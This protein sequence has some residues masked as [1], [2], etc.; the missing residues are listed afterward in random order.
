MQEQLDEAQQGEE[1]E[2]IGRTAKVRADPQREGGRGERARDECGDDHRLRTQLQLVRKPDE[3]R[4]EP[5][6]GR[7]VHLDDVDVEALPGED[8]FVDGN[9]PRHVAIDR[10]KE[11]LDECRD[12][13]RREPDRQ[14]RTEP[15]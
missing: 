13:S 4:V 8:L 12:D 14:R 2:R 5:D 3:R 1:D 6:R 10:H 9:Q 15:W 7:R 11:R